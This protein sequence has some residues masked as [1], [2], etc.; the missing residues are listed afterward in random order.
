MFNVDQVGMDNQVQRN[1]DIGSFGSSFET[2][3]KLLCSLINERKNIIPPFETNWVDLRA[4]TIFLLS[5]CLFLL[6]FSSLLRLPILSSQLYNQD[7]CIV[8]MY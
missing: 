1:F 6:S 4:S 3:L 2:E 7:I 5:V 8:Y